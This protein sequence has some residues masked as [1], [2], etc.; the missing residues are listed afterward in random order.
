MSQ[1][2]ITP[3]YPIQERLRRSFG[4][5]VRPLLALIILTMQASFALS[6]QAATASLSG[7]VKDPNGAVV[8]NAQVTVTQK[9]TG[10]RRETTTNDA[11]LYVLSNL[12]PSDYELRV[13]SKG[14]A[15]KVFSTVTIQVGQSSTLDITLEVNLKE[16][17]V[18]DDHLNYEMVNT[19]TSVV[20]GVIRED[21]LQ[22]LP[23]NGRNFLELALLIPGNAPAPNFDPTKTNTVVIS[24]AG[25]LGR[26]GNVT[27]DGADDN[28]DVVGG[29]LQNI[30]QEAVQEFQIAT[31]R[32]SAQLGRSGSA[33]V[34][35]VTK[36]G[37]NEY[38]GSA[39]FYFRDKALQ[40]LPA[41]FDRS[42]GQNPPFDREQYA[43]AFGGPVKKD[44][45][46]FFGALEFRNQDG[47]ALVGSRDLASR[48][49]RRGF[50][51]A[52]LNDLL[53]T[54]RV[55]WQ[56]GDADRVSFRYSLQREDDVAASTLDR[57]I[58]SS[59][60]RQASTN[61][62]HFFLTNYTRILNPRDV[63]S[64][65]FSFS[66]FTNDIEPVSP[67]PQLT[68]PSIQDGAS[69][70][71][72]QGTKQRRLQFSDTLTMIRGNHTWNFGGELQRVD[73]DFDLRV[74]QQGRIEMIEDF[75]DFDRNGDGRVDDNDLL[76]AVTLRSGV[77]TQPLLIPNADNFYFAGFV[78]DDWRVHPQLTLNLG[79]RYELDTDVKNVSR[80]NQLNPII[81]PFL[82]G[83]RTRDKNN[84]GP[85]V[86]FNYAAKDGR[87]SIHGGYG[88]Y[89]DRITLEI[90]SLERGL[91][92]RALPIEVRAGPVF[93]IPP[94]FLFDRVNGTFPPGA[95]T[96]ANPFSGFLLP[97]AGA[98]GINIID[99]GMQNP[100]VQQSNLGIQRELGRQ[101][102]V[103][104]DY[105]HN[106]GT[107]FIIGRTIG[108]VFNPIV[109]GPDLVKNLESSVKTKYDGLL[110][111]LE[112]RFSNRYQ[113]RASYTLSKSFNYAN[114]DQ[115]P[116]SEGPINPNNLQLEY[117]PTP[118]DQRHRFSFA[119]VVELPYNVNLSS[120]FTLASGVPM[121]ILLPGASQRVPQ[122]QRNAGGRLFHNGSELNAFITQ[123]NSASVG[124]LTAP[125]PLVSDNAR[126]DDSFN[127]LDLRVSK[128]FKFGERIR[129]EPM[130][131][132]FNLFNVTNVLGSSKSNYSGFA[133]VLVR[134]SNDPT[135]PGFLRSSSFGQP[136]T[137]AGGVFGSGGPRAFQFAARLVF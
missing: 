115:I 47:A 103:R 100:M 50:A 57:A 118:N 112:K 89:Y 8:A 136:V 54:V 39:S 4:S 113:L 59:S 75:P 27:V 129:L 10:N 111:S 60:Q 14:F 15:N 58:G 80:I 23:L 56:P 34:N 104:A 77:P 132:V 70:R 92:G 13:V 66:S 116:F 109:G 2:A 101:Y 5:S 26:G 131:E 52:P 117:G 61:H 17:V 33:V 90:Q 22:S 79:L 6:Q 81:L 135:N 99:N 82:H 32:F 55:D 125:L 63:N 11:G 44:H 38:H 65:N 96:L 53:G 29:Q 84:F 3:R 37:T 46:W 134:D 36:S 123:L 43:F 31:N 128:V 64:F 67:G 110:V 122:L 130:A 25:Q 133:N 76:F 127:S 94:Q 12:P 91:D 72:P 30:S 97:G 62:T 108:S 83:K 1:L 120:I 74:F 41:T 121:D 137:T 49:I 114:D 18:I 40:G 87:T 20:D 78:Q 102:V 106:F 69:F 16:T 51:P 7:T 21:E 124:G 28:D 45:A 105:V 9:A 98:A 86:G 24:S 95:P 88:I 119:G 35:I 19:T 85:R 126:F 107:H 93:F 73:A 48:S 71:V 42:L 68:F